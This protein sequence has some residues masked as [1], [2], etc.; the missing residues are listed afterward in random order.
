LLAQIQHFDALQNAAL[1]EASAMASGSLASEIFLQKAISIGVAL[2]DIVKF[3]IA[4]PYT[5]EI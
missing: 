5:F 2:E 3:V 1:H 4:L